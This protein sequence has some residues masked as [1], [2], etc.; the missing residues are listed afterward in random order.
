[1]NPERWQ[2]ITNIFQAA[3][4]CPTDERAAYL[5]DV[6][7]ADPALRREVETMLAAHA[8]AGR[9]LEAPA[10]Q[11][12][13]VLFAGEQAH[14][15]A[16]GQTLNHYRIIALIG[17]GGMGEVYLAQDT[18]LERQVALKVL[19]A[20][21]AAD[22][23]RMRR[24]VQEAKAA[25]ALNHP[26]ILTIYE[27][28]EVEGLRFM[29]AEYVKGETLTAVL[30]HE[31]LT[32][33]QTLDVAVQILSALQAAHEAG[34]IHRDIK[35]DNVM[36]RPDG[37]VKILD[38]GIAKLAERQLPAAD[39][40][41]ATAIK[42]ETNPGMVIGTAAY[43]SPEQARGK[44]VDARSDIFSFGVVFYE[45]LTGARPFDGENALDVIAS[46]LHREP[47]PVRQLLPDVP[48]DIERIVSKA[49]R[50]DREERYQTAKDL[51]IDLKD[52]KQEL[53]FQHKLERTGTP[54]RAAVE[55][56][57]ANAT[58]AGAAHT[59]SSAEYIAAE[60]KRH[61]RV[62]FG[63][64]ALVVLA[65]LGL[66]YWFYATRVVN[67][68]R[69]ESIA[70]LPLRNE[71][72]NADLEYLSDGMTESLINSLSQLPDMK[73]IARSSVFRYKGKEVDVQQAAKEL[74]VR[75]VLTGRVMQRGDTLDVSIDLTDTQNNT[76]LWG[77]HFTRKTA[78]IFAVQDEIAQQ[79]TSALRLRLTGAQAERVVKRYTADEEAYRLYLQGRFYFNKHT[80]DGARKAI[81]YY[82]QA[83]ARDPAYA[84]A[85]AG[86][87]DAYDQ[88]AGAP[89]ASPPEVYP[90]AR[91]AVTE[92]LR[93]DNNLAEAHE[94]LGNIK[95]DYDWDVHGAEG[96]YKEALALNPNDAVAHDSYG[97]LLMSGFGRFDEALA[98]FKRAQ[99]LDPLS[100]Y[101]AK[102]LGTYCLFTHQYDRA[103]VYL[104]KTL[105]LEPNFPMTYMDTGFS[106]AQKGQYPE[107]LAQFQKMQ[108]LEPE[109]STALSGQGYVYALWGKDGEAHQKIK[110]LEAMSARQYVAV[111]VASVYAGLGDKD[112][113]FA[114]LE[115][116][117]QQRD[118][119]MINL[120]V[121][122]TFEPLHSDPRFQALLRRV[123]LPQ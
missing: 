47:A 37:L 30:K 65:A 83:T 9:F 66:G 13:A 88:L 99:E 6:C 121:H 18:R 123:G 8:A 100:P 109:S 75:A 35:P 113:V 58:T 120:R 2:Q 38:F 86:L 67:A 61:K 19:R 23:E 71:S 77:Q 80:N 87:A 79:A 59:T 101:I 28:G 25:S 4:A 117:Y 110:E 64:L 89:G 41:A 55:T 48:R 49:L 97:G 39:S 82:K 17:A 22:K 118:P 78:D 50:K 74:N 90:Q 24:F 105:E 115:K 92:A 52:V 119:Q 57:T 85:Y 103:L 46:I 106:Y 63:A 29:A 111:D 72:G 12:A 98:H 34:I 36:L 104:Q 84:L 95:L 116:G 68:N 122:P 51:L 107:A 40:E 62:V 3:L 32:L 14:T 21:T 94:A 60:I 70:V 93:L 54:P 56:E 1:M 102:H 43:M 27:T 42:V 112:Q 15:L 108:Q 44:T 5:A 31:G 33:K 114:W 10:V 91:A 53:E 76:Q 26:N 20:E 45:M 81:D 16:V 7:A 73:V 69:I 96:A 11:D